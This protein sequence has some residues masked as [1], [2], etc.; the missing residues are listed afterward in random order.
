[1]K[2]AGLQGRVGAILIIGCVL[3]G[4]TDSPTPASLEVL[5]AQQSSFDGQRVRTTGTLREFDD[6]HHVWIEDAGLNRVELQPADGL[7]D[8]VGQEVEV[9]GRFRYQADAGRRI[10]LESVKPAAAG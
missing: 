5:V 9:V 3:A 2:A 6:P 8:R 7:S 10:Q 1:M 4:C